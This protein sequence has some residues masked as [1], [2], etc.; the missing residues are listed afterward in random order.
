MERYICSR[1]AAQSF[2]I[3]NKSLVYH[4]FFQQTRSFK[5]KLFKFF[6]NF[7]V[8]FYVYKCFACI[9]VCA[10]H[11][12]LVCI[13]ATRRLEENIRLPGTGTTDDCEPSHVCWVLWKS[14]HSSSSLSI[15]ENILKNI[16]VWLMQQIQQ[17]L[18]F[19]STG[20]VSWV[21]C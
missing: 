13:E 1:Y 6:K 19:E 21:R 16:S 10:L 3:F 5:R 2:P 17:I 20:K 11:G 4:I 14:R 8:F 7:K 9:Y 18:D 15:R 12:C